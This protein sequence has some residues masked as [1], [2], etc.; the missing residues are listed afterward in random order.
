MRTVIVHPVIHDSMPT[1][2]CFFCGDAVILRGIECVD[3]TAHDRVLGM[4][5]TTCLQRDPEQLQAL[6]SEKANWRRA[7]YVTLCRRAEGLLAEAEWL[8]RL[9]HQP[10]AMPAAAALESIPL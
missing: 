10:L 7:Q 3:E 6:L 8:E 5:C 4:V 1:N 2:S 9:A